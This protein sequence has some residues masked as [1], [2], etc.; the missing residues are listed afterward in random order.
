MKGFYIDPQPDGSVR[1]RL[2]FKDPVTG[3]TKRLSMSM[4]SDTVRNRRRAETELMER[5]QVV[6]SAPCVSTLQKT[7]DAYLLEKSH[8]WRESTALRNKGVMA[9]MLRKLPPDAVIDKLTIAHW[10]KALSELSDGQAGTYNEYI[11]RV[12]PFLRWCEQ[13]EYITGN[14]S[15][16]LVPIKKGKSELCDPTDKYL[17]KD[18]VDALLPALDTHPNA[19]WSQLARFMLLSGLRFGE[20]VALEDADISARYIHVDKTFYDK[21]KKI[22]PPKT[23][24]SNR[25][26]SITPELAGLI[27]EIRE[28]NAWVKA[29]LG[30]ITPLFFFSEKKAGYLSLAAF[31]QALKKKAAVSIGHPLSSHWLR[32]THASFLLAAGV[33]IDVI[34]RRLGHDTTQITEKVYLHIIQSLREKDADRLDEI[35]LLGSGS[36]ESKIRKIN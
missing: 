19:R 24:K 7:I 31:D 30:L 12:K 3:K 32:H 9:V 22:G 36:G 16:K 27:K 10:K 23:K 6:S 11:R 33:P 1:Y 5:A 34:S 14:V 29:S 2:A 28:Y 20:A 26:V 13:N 8:I 25:D 15:A 18:E 17:E 4:P 21:T 35:T